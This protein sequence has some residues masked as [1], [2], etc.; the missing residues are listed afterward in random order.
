VFHRYWIGSPS[1]WFNEGEAFGWLSTAAERLVKPA[2]RVLLTAGALETQAVVDP[3]QRLASELAAGFPS[4]EVR[5]QVFPDETHMSVLGA[6]LSRALPALYGMK[7]ITL[8]REE[9][10]GYAATWRGDSGEIMEIRLQRDELIATL[11]VSSGLRLEYALA[12]ESAD[13][14]FFAHYE[15]I[16]LSVGRDS[17]GRPVRLRRKLFGQHHEF[18]RSVTP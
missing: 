6:S 8:S 5:A 15:Q 9:L 2:G 16:R 14:L 18:H 10:D 11:A 7:S 4:L 1:L 12:A 13:E 3:L 17:K